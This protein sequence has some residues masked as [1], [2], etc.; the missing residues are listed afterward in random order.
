[1]VHAAATL[2][3]P[4]TVEAL[5]VLIV[6]DSAVAR[7]AMS[8][9]VSGTP[10]LDVAAALPGA[11]AAVAWLTHNRVDVVI[12]DLDMPGIDGLAALPDLLEAG[13]GARVLIVSSTARDGAEATMRA[14]AL[15]ATDTLSKPGAGQLNQNFGRLLIDRLFRLGLARTA[16]PVGERFPLRRAPDAPVNL[17]AIAASTGG[18]NALAAFFARLEPGFTAPILLTQHL[19]PSFMPLFAE[20]VTA[21][22]GRVARVAT[23]GMPLGE[24]EIAIAPGDAHVGVTSG[25]GRWNAALSKE[26]AASGHIPSADPMFTSVAK[27]ADARS[28]AVVLTGMGRDGALGA[29]LLVRCGGTVIAQ[30]AETSAVWGMPGVVAR[31]GLASLVASPARLADYLV[32]RG[33]A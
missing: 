11:S 33:S 17:L 21:M 28:V 15:G 20:Q 32:R 22:S 27:I 7:A 8:R 2:N 16:A 23:E 1:V 31:A 29:D 5:S 4:S 10:G 25:A 9:M 6:D 12:L 3:K 13:R 18:L 26:V 19:P 30:D 14:L 24:R